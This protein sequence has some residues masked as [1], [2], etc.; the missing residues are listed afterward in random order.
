MCISQERIERAESAASRAREAAE[1]E[2]LETER[3]R[4]EL[5]AAL[6]R[7]QQQRRTTV[8]A[9][10][11]LR[12]H[13]GTQCEERLRE[14]RARAAQELVLLREAAAAD[15]EVALAGHVA[16]LDVIRGTRTH[17]RL[18][19]EAQAHE[20]TEAQR[21]RSAKNA[22]RLRAVI[23]SEEACQ[24]QCE[25]LHGRLR[26]LA[27]TALALAARK[28]WAEVEARAW[29]TGAHALRRDV[30]PLE[31]ELEASERTRSAAAVAHERQ[32][33]GLEGAV[34]E[35]RVQCHRVQR[36]ERA[37]RKEQ[38]WAQLSTQQAQLRAEL[39][40][41]HEHFA[42]AAAL[43]EAEH[44]DELA[45]LRT[46]LGSANAALREVEAAMREGGD[47][48]LRELE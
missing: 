24:A 34:E 6:Q 7:A 22:E 45:A 17:E 10:A 1:A 44:R 27:Q 13:L 41:A 46:Q 28:R 32:L 12:A 48:L 14:E 4:A 16:E 21:R 42:A 18:L 9:E 30:A 23:S 33:A 43:R 38:C 40:R 36:E 8:A 19:S 3:L 11:A 31:A 20:A 35:M 25:A 26:S 39:E 29:T 47:A 37:R 2:R 5:A 15:A